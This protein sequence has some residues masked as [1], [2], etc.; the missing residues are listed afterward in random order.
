MCTREEEEKWA[1]Q[2][3]KCIAGADEAGAGV[4]A[5]PVTVCACYV[6]S[7]VTIKG[8]ND[9]KKLTPKR[10]E[11]LYEKIIKHPDIKYAIVHIGSDIVDEINI[12][13]ARFEG[14]AQAYR[15]LKKQV[16][17][18][19]LVLLDGNQIPPQ[20]AEEKVQVQAIVGGDA[21]C[22]CIGMASVLAKV[23]RDRLMVEYDKQYPGYGLAAHKGYH[24]VQHVTS[25]QTLG[26]TPIHR[27]TFKGVKP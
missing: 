5:G 8:I 23:T 27:K 24:T 25:I 21:L 9:S 14:F 12:L 11:A 17:D 22:Y 2:G 4:L 19:D 7:T 10:R 16:P 13:Q 18:I 15:N 26:A 6:P 20:L 3:F 1:L